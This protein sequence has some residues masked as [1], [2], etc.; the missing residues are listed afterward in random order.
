MAIT[1]ITPY[2]PL[3]S[4][5]SN[6]VQYPGKLKLDSR[7]REKYRLARSIITDMISTID[8]ELYMAMSWDKEDIREKQRHARAD[9]RRY[10][11]ALSALGSSKESKTG[12][13]KEPQHP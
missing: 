13:S 5:D 12:K 6:I 4:S 3:W 1:V 8:Q 9:L 2:R 7:L 11:D 10:H